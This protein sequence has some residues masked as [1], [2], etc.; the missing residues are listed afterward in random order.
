MVLE[1][2]EVS[3]DVA[4]RKGFFY[5]KG[6]SGMLPRMDCPTVVRPRVRGFL[7][8]AGAPKGGLLWEQRCV[9]ARA[10][11]CVV[12]GGFVLLC[13]LPPGVCLR[14]MPCD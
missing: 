8:P 5:A 6:G 12:F 4:V 7:V 13:A 2:T 14:A 1:V 11:S 10:C 9:C 3:E